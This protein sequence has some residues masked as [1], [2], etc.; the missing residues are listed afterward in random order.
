MMF[1]DET[2]S[3]EFKVVGSGHKCDSVFGVVMADTAVVLVHNLDQRCF[4]DRLCIWFNF[5]DKMCLGACP[6][7]IVVLCCLM[8]GFSVKDQQL[9]VWKSSTGM[10]QKA[11]WLK[12]TEPI[13]GLRLVTLVSCQC[14]GNMCDTRFQI[15]HSTPCGF[16]QGERAILVPQ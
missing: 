9:C 2:I 1:K 15:P 7:G 5:S 16:L 12:V 3:F 14:Q 10:R 13:H 8:D 4:D 11:P 6:C